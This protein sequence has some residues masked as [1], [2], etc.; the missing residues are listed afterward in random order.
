M[1]SGHLD[2][3]RFEALIKPYR[4]TRAAIAEQNP[5]S[6]KP[7]GEHWVVWWCRLISG[8]LDLVV[9]IYGGVP[10]RTRQVGISAKLLVC[11]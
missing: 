6:E 11:R 5:V 4:S 1:I 3:V 10:L 7:V 2:L 8:D 9:S